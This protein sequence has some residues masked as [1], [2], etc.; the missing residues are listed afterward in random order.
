MNVNNIVKGRR[1]LH[2]REQCE[3]LKRAYEADEGGLG[4]QP[5]FLFPL[6]TRGSSIAI[7]PAES[8]KHNQDCAQGLI[9][10]LGHVRSEF[11]EILIE[12]KPVLEKAERTWRD[13]IAA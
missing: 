6:V 5:S 10:W 2:T 3:L 13:C 12:F 4:L 7:T 1:E 11:P 9:G 8:R